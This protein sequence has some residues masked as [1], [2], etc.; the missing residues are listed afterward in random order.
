MAC[1]RL[2]SRPESSAAARHADLTNSVPSVRAHLARN[3]RVRKHPASPNSSRVYPL[4]FA[5]RRYFLAAR[6]RPRDDSIYRARFFPLLTSRRSRS[7]AGRTLA[8]PV[9]FARDVDPAPVPTTFYPRRRRPRYDFSFYSSDDRAPYYT[10]LSRRG[11][12]AGSGPADLRRTSRIS[13]RL[14]PVKSDKTA[15]RPVVLLLLQYIHCTVARNPVV[16]YVLVTDH[17]GS[18]D[19]RFNSIQSRPGPTRPHDFAARR[20]RRSNVD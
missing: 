1:Y 20:A 2:L 6:S 18:L 3:R 11:K 10:P 14:L 8:F 5:H 13:S 9:V 16:S 17:V 12:C 4:R 19:S 7:A 15:I